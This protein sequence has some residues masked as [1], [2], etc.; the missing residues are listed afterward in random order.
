MRNRLQTQ[1]VV[2]VKM[3]LAV[4]CALLGTTMRDVAS[5]QSSSIEAS[6]GGTFIMLTLCAELG[7]F[8]EEHADHFRCLGNELI[9]HAES[10]GVSSRDIA[11]E[12]TDFFETLSNLELSPKHETT[13]EDQLS[14]G[15][16]CRFGTGGEPVHGWA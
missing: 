16:V 4:V 7:D 15:S 9:D 1:R 3:A 6:V 5:E 11:L 14:H 10:R 2:F 13:L 8:N 12:M